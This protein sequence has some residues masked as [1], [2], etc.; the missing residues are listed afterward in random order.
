MRLMFLIR[1]KFKFLLMSSKCFQ[2]R[3][4]RAAFVRRPLQPRVPDVGH[5]RTN[6]EGA[7]HRSQRR[8]SP[9]Q[10]GGPQGGGVPETEGSST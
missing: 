9:R 7:D 2:H 1:Q 10:H 4:R 8:R 6:P 3:R 5:V